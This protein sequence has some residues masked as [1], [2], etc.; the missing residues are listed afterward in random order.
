MTSDVMM[1]L[2]LLFLLI[3]YK[4]KTGIHFKNMLFLLGETM[5]VPSLGIYSPHS[6][7]QLCIFGIP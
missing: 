2:L 1:L 7:P 6:F 4:E 5:K 3:I